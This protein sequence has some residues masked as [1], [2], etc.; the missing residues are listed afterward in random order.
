MICLHPVD[1]QACGKVPTAAIKV[2][3]G[4][5]WLETSSERGVVLSSSFLPVCDEHR[6]CYP[7]FDGIE[8]EARG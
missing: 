1:G 7:D 5:G 4:K 8:L 6:A 3:A 2:R